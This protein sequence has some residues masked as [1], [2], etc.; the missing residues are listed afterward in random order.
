MSVPSSTTSSDMIERGYL[1]T[2]A[3]SVAALCGLLL[4][5]TLVIDPYGVS[6]VRLNL[7][8]INTQKPKRLDIDRVIKPYEVWRYQPRTVFLGTSRIHQGV[9]PTILDGT[10][11]EPAYNASIPAS[12]LAMNVAH[13][14]QYLQ[15]DPELRTVMV[16]LF[17]YT[18]FEHVYPKTPE[19][20]SG[21]MSNSVTLFA[22]I[23][24]L[25][26]S[27]CTL[28]YNAVNGRPTHEIKP[29]GYLS[30]PPGHNSQGPFDGFAA[31]VWVHHPKKPGGPKLAP[32]AIDAVRMMID[33]A[34]THVLELIFLAT[35]NHAYVDYY[36]DAIGA[37]D[38]LEEWLLK[39][40][41]E[42]T[43]YSFSQPNHWVYEPV[44]P[45]MAYWNDPFH[46]SLMM[47]N[48]MQ[49]SLAGLNVAGLP[50]NFIE[51][52]TPERVASHIDSRR[53]AARQWAQ[54]NPAFVMRFEEERRKWL[55]AQSAA[56][57]K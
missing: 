48:G 11:F 7:A 34:R 53:R 10:R 6:P 2:F 20:L 36:F 43:V 13:L 32:A 12:S 8:W 1:S 5:F 45:R 54:A 9:D 3:L 41:A 37:W 24:T 38:V 35:P 21:F 15:L 18:F 40:T 51:R 16:E 50:E 33:L 52:L 31:G 25:W 27:I 46:F 19:E 56:K 28:A 55:A 22:S 29:G 23:D 39:L 17:V 30:Y 57:S 26:A 47:G 44:G 42:A 49:A 14:R 4:A